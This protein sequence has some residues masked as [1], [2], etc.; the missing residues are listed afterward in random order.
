MLDAKSLRKVIIPSSL[1][2]NPSP[3]HTQSTRLALHVDDDVC[4]VFIASDC[5]VYNIQISLKETEESMVIQGK[6]GLLIP[7]QGQVVK[8]SLVD[9][10][11]HRSEIQSIVLT[12]ESDDCLALVMGTVDSFGH[13]IVSQLD[14]ISSDFDRVSYSVPNQHCGL[15]ESSWAGMCF[16]P[17]RWSMTAVAHGFSKCIDVYDQDI[18][19]RSFRTLWYPAS[20]AFLKG[21]LAADSSSTLVIAEG[22]QISVWDLRS[23]SNGG[24]VQRVSGSIGDLLYSVSSSPSG[25]IAAGGSDRTVTIYD[26]R[27]WSSLSRW[28]HC[29]KYEITNISFSSLE[30]NYMYVQGVDYEVFCG[31]WKENNKKTFS[32]RGDSNWLGFNKCGGNKDVLAGWCESGSIF[33]ADVAQQYES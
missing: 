14:M 17:S 30:Q 33:V 18:P 19:L 15:G 25:L 21:S 4:S 16:S 11:P 29:S 24:C 7:I 32:F 26:P 2:P 22:S 10:C 5:H 6:D 1:I 12:E 23:N 27:R 3:A 28:V 13:L 9:R 20:L 8:S 31:Q